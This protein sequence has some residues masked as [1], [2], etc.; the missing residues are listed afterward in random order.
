MKLG[1]DLEF[2]GRTAELRAAERRGPAEAAGRHGAL[3]LP[4]RSLPLIWWGYKMGGGGRT[5]GT[6]GRRESSPA[7]RRGKWGRRSR[8]RADFG[9]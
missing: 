9:Q 4:R 1:A 7:R 2:E 3:Q 5:S 6:C 8:Q